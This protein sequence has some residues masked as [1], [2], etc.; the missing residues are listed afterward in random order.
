MDHHY[1]ISFFTE[2]QYYR[3]IK[4]INSKIQADM[5][6]SN[7]YVKRAKIH[8]EHNNIEFAL[9]DLLLANAI[10][11]DNIEIIGLLMTLYFEKGDIATSNKYKI[12]YQL[13]EHQ[14]KSNYEKEA[15]Q[16]LL[17]ISRERIAIRN[18][19]NKTDYIPTML[20]KFK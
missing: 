1:R 15:I 7:L 19:V 13:L 18:L 12:K 10:D 14:L 20:V 9:N 17:K 8:K 3:C 11:N 5:E 2:N 6:N 4:E 16:N